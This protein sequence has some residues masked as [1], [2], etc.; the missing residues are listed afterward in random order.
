MNELPIL[1]IGRHSD[2][3]AVTALLPGTIYGGSGT[4]RVN[5]GVTNSQTLRI[6]G[7]D[8]NS[9]IDS[10]FQF[11]SNP[12][13]DAVE[14]F[15]V[16]TSNFAAEFGQ[17]GGGLF[18][19]TMRSGSN[20]IHGSAYEYFA[21]E[22]LNAS[23]GYTNKKPRNRRN[24]YG[25]TFGG[26]VYIPGVYN[27]RDKTFFYFSF[28]QN[29]TAP[30]YITPNTVPPRHAEWDF[31]AILGTKPIITDPLGRPVYENE[32][33]NPFYTYPGPN[34][35][36][37]RDPFMGCD[38]NTMNVICTDPT[39]QYYTQ[40]DSVALNI[41]ALDPKPTTSGLTNNYYPQMLI[42]QV[43][44]IP[45]VK[46]DHYFSPKIKLSG[47]WSY[48]TTVT[49]GMTD[50]LDWPGT[51]S[52]TNPQK[53]HTIRLN[54]DQ[55]LTPTLLFH[56]G[57]GMMY[58]HWGQQQPPFDNLGELGLKGTYADFFPTIVGLF[59]PYGGHYGNFSGS[60]G[61][62]QLYDLYDEKPTTN[63]SITWVRK[64]HTYK[65]G[66]E[67][68]LGG[69]PMYLSWPSNGYF[70]F[71]AI[72]SGLPWTYGQFL[73]GKNVG[74]PYASFLLG[75]VNTGSIGPTSQTRVGKQAWALFVQDTWKVTP[76]LTLDYGLRWDYQTY[77]KEQYGRV[78][79]I[80]G[81]VPNPSTGNLP[82]GVIFEATSG[83]FASNYAYAIGPRLGVAYQINPKTVLR[84][85]WGISYGQT[86]P[87]NFWSMRFGSNVPFAAPAW[88]AAMLLR[89]GIPIQPTWPDFD[90]G[91][92]PAIPSTPT[93]FLTLI[94][95]QAGRP[96]RIMQWSIGLQRQIT[97][98]LSVEAAYVGNRGVWWQAGAIND[99]NRLT[100]EILAANHLDI[101]K[102]ADRD[103]LLAPLNSQLAISRGFGTPP[104]PEFST[105]LPVNQALR[106]YPQ[107][108]GI[109]V[110]WSPLGNTWYDSLQVKVTKRYSHGLDLSAAYSWQKELTLG[111][112]ETGDAAFCP[113]R[114]HKQL[115]RPE[116]QQVPFGYS[117]PIVWLSPELSRTHM[118]YK[119][120]VVMDFARLDVWR[121]GNLRQ[122]TADPRSLRE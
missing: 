95:P 37:M 94:D 109:N 52:Y 54:Y 17:A 79:S 33:Y 4:I 55:T 66:A 15:A 93:S 85:G 39:S 78:P 88:R 71:T 28:E 113:Q 50:G 16:Q 43:K 76:K 101:S 89:D 69:N 9:G 6:E 27:G 57:A 5:G 68:R 112:G 1:S 36:V 59:T 102:K 34:N 31:R 61:A 35:E 51:T 100:P 118:E 44:S 83:P 45:S 92:F 12:S 56:F 77:L 62:N 72:E 3:Y 65:A 14:E 99:P 22:A 26:P 73:G 119:Q 38:G 64:N 87:N 2:P 116:G 13:V 41:Q 90:P 115:A 67:L 111:S 91:Q 60:M 30:M 25:F 104:Y 63:A 106:P 114:F 80:S 122:R 23:M 108:T 74:F 29:R 53:T 40:L 103:L 24:D 117:F 120:G 42:P 110:L 84:G 49:P 86:A 19:L 20:A 107:F 18:N 58:G 121:N 96:P 47:F 97:T 82:G 11:I 46:I 21:N 75:A 105:S 8:S 32:I 10:G 7:Q 98:N 70:S 48:A 81:E